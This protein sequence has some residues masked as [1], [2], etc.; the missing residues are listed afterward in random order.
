MYGQSFYCESNICKQYKENATV[1]A[2]CDKNLAHPCASNLFCNATTLVCQSR[3]LSDSSCYC[4]GCDVC[5]SGYYCD[6]DSTLGE[7]GCIAKKALQGSCN[8]NHYCLS[9]FCNASV[10]ENYPALFSLAAGENIQFAL[11]AS[12]ASKYCM[13]GW[14]R[15]SGFGGYT[16]LAVLNGTEGADCS[17]N[18]MCM[19]GLI[20]NSTSKCGLP[21]S[22]LVNAPCL[23][24]DECQ[25][26]LRCASEMNNT[27]QAIL[28]SPCTQNT[29]NGYECACNLEKNRTYIT[30]TTG[31]PSISNYCPNE[32][33]I[34]DMCTPQELSLFSGNPL[35][36]LESNPSAHCKNAILD[37]MCC[38]SQN[39]ICPF[40][41]YYVSANYI[42]FTDFES[43]FAIYWFSTR[44]KII[45]LKC[46]SE[47]KTITITPAPLGTNNCCRINNATFFSCNPSRLKVDCFGSVTP[48]GTT[49]A[50][51]TTMVSMMTLFTC[52]V[53]L[54]LIIV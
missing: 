37:Y 20:C 9:D 12:Q 40:V 11:T 26:G 35:V 16:C 29:Y 24:I 49:G 51:S 27:C 23:N 17:D 52:L 25:K 22:K 6:F 15:Y 7:N 45:D 13:S 14:V 2:K 21:F 47:P 34:Y 48:T 31:V 43:Q 18:V 41:N 36:V 19:K 44:D 38:F 53:F 4:A 8:A 3:Y 5:V 46:K 28:N 33:T 42:S 30:S 32:R 54:L 39:G 50:A 1:N 10:C